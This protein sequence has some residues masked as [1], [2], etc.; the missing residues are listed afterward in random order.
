MKNYILMV[1]LN[2]F[3]VINVFSQSAK[4]WT[5][6]QKAPSYIGGETA[7]KSFIKQNLRYPTQDD[8]EGTVFVGFTIAAEGSVT[9]IQIKKSL[10]PDLDAEAIRILKLMPKWIPAIDPDGKNVPCMMTYPLKFKLE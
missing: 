9:D 5:V 6:I 7:L 3:F 4:D 2:I 1:F 8:I 10:R